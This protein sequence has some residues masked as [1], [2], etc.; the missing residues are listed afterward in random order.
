MKAQESKPARP[1]VRLFVLLAFLLLLF[2][3]A[4]KTG[5]SEALNRKAIQ[6]AIQG[7]GLP[8]FLTFLAL[9]A[10]GELFHVPGIVFVLAAVF[11]YGPILGFG[12]SYVGALTSVSL[13]FWVVRRIGGSLLH[14]SKRPMIQKMLKRIESHPILTVALLRLFLFLLPP[15]NY[16]LALT[17]IRYRDYLIGS[18][19]GLV[20]PLALISWGF[21]QIAYH[22]G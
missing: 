21:E 15:L 10:V 8:G 16:F 14:T 6:S 9:F 3:I 13:S 22:W 18:A 11:A 19:L 5:I 4:H 2:A 1:L 7:F 20:P 17:A 12:A